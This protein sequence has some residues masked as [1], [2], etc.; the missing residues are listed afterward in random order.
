MTLPQNQREARA[1]FVLGVV[2]SDV[3]GEEFAT[4]LYRQ[5]LRHNPY[6]VPAYVRLGVSYAYAA[7]YPSMLGAFEK[8]IG[9]DPAAARIAACEEPAEALQIKR[10][11]FPPE[12]TS[13]E[14]TYVSAMPAEFKVAGDL[15]TM[16]MQHLAAGRDGEAVR[17]LERSLSIDDTHDFAVALLSLTYLLLRKQNGPLEGARGK[18]MLWGIAPD[19]AAYL[20]SSTHGADTN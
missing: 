9:L 17:A 20:L 8:A 18:S 5:A 10:I 13:T 19:L 14:G 15:V 6:L 16:S 4:E 1:R 12:P 11:L 3:C 2:L 7:D